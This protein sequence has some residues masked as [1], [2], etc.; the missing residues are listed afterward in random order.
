MIIPIAD[1]RHRTAGRRSDTGFRVG[2]AQLG[3]CV[4]RAGVEARRR[5]AR[6]ARSDRSVRVNGGAAPS[7]VEVPV[8][9]Q[10]PHQLHPLRTPTDLPA[11][12]HGKRF[13]GKFRSNFNFL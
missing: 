1:S 7:A 8:L 9:E 4:S 10:S 11:D 2:A 6:S 3:G 12:H 5:R 13:C